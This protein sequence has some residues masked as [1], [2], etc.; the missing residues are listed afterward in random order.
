MSDRSCLVYIGSCVAG[1]LF[2]SRRNGFPS[3]VSSQFK[4]LMQEDCKVSKPGE[5]NS[6]AD[7]ADARRSRRYDKDWSTDV[8]TSVAP[9]S[10]RSS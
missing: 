4:P 6:T 7:D 1:V 3:L 9:I 8:R 10:S 5:E 2:R